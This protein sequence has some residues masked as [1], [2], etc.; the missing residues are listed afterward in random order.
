[1]E[2]TVI[3][4]ALSGGGI[5]GAKGM[6]PVGWRTANEL[7]PP[8]AGTRGQDVRPSHAGAGDL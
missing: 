4:A 7:A 2:R 3:G 1:L 8:A 6:M 5:H